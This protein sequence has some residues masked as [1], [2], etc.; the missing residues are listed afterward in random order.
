MSFSLV[1]IRLL[2][3]TRSSLSCWSTAFVGADEEEVME[4]RAISI[5]FKGIPM[6][7]SLSQGSCQRFGLIF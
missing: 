6:A 4:A 1:L 5:P 3:L 7:S 2:R